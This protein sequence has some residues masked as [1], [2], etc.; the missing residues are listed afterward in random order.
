MSKC[1]CSIDQ[2]MEIGCPSTK[3]GN[4]PSEFKEPTMD[5]IWKSI[6]LNC[7]VLKDPDDPNLLHGYLIDDAEDGLEGVD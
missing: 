3:N 1:Y 5:D 7:I 6:Q 2:L 4:C